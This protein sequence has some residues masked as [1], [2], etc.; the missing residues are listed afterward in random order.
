[1]S[2]AAVAGIDNDPLDPADVAVGGMNVLAPGHFRLAFGHQIGGHRLRDP[3]HG[4]GAHSRHAAALGIRGPRDDLFQAIV[5]VAPRPRQEL[6]LIGGLELPELRDRAPEPDHLTGRGSY[7][8]EWNKLSESLPVRFLDHQIGDGIPGGVDDQAS[9]L[10][11][12]PVG[13]A[14]VSS[15]PEHQRWLSHNGPPIALIRL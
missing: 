7:L 9:D 3:R 14:D 4:V 8:V 2:H 1:M 13:A 6:R 5:L 10:A 11:A 15:D 12:G